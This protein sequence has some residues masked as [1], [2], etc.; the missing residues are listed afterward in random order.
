MTWSLDPVEP[1]D[2]PVLEDDVYSADEEDEIATRLE[3]LGYL[4]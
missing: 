1:E 4:D 2:R 3:A